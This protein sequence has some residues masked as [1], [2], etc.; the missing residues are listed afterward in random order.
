M[1][2]RTQKEKLMRMI[3]DHTKNIYKESVA[4]SITLYHWNKKLRLNQKLKIVYN[5]LGIDF[6]IIVPPQWKKKY[7]PI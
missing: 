6:E 3:C 4:D 7:N 2:Q 1:R 5:H